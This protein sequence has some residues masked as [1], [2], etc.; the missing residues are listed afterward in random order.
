VLHHAGAEPSSVLP[1]V[2]AFHVLRPLSAA[3]ADA[4]WPLV[5]LRGA[6]LVASGRH[7]AAIDTGNAYAADGLDAEWRILA[8]AASVPVEVMTALVRDAVGLAAP[9]LEARGGRLVRETPAVLDPSV[10]SD[11]VDRGAWLEPDLADRLAAG[12]PTVTEYGR[13]RLAGAPVLAAASPASTPTG[14]DMWNDAELLAPWAGTVTEAPAER[15]VLAADTLVL[16]LMGAVGTPVDSG[17]RLA[18]GDRSAVAGGRV[19]VGVRRAGTPEPP[20][21]VRPE[22]APGWLA[23]TADPAPLLG[24]ATTVPEGDDLL[25]RR[26]AAL[27]D[28]QEH[29]YDDPPRIERGWRHHLAATDGRVFLDM[30]NNVSVL[31]RAHPRVEEAVA[32][33]LRRLNTNSRFHFRAVVEFAERLAG[34]L[35][36]PLDTVFLVNSGSEAD[37][38]AIR[39]AHAATGRRDVVTRSPPVRTGCT[40]STRPTPTAACTATPR[41]TPPRRWP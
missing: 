32:R 2:R 14:V 1:A 38:L 30:V 33:Q 3:E 12:R 18:T 19:H 8:H 15:L 31:G 39:L 28:V 35:P 4:L 25:A 23:L 34:L 9:P 13:A 17:A 37:D 21:L 24:L 16:T 36:D 6:V 41:A 22:Y 7:Q 10:G 26:D 27:A 5:V 20:P 11:A 40:P 29:Y